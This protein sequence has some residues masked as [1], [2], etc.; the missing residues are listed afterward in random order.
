MTTTTRTVGKLPPGP[1][2]LPM[3]GSLLDVRKNPHEVLA[4]YAR[5]YGDVCMFRLGGSPTVSISHPAILR[6][7]LA[8]DEL[9]DR[10]TK[11]SWRSFL[12]DASIL[13]MGYSNQRWRVHQR[14][15]N[16]NVLSHRR[17]SAM[18]DAYIEPIID[19]ILDTVGEFADSG[20]YMHPRDTMFF[21]NARIMIDLIFGIFGLSQTESTNQNL[22]NILKAVRI[23]FGPH[24]CLAPMSLL[25][26]L[27]NPVDNFLIPRLTRRLLSDEAV[28]GFS[29]DIYKNHPLFDLDHPTCL[30]EVLLS[31]EA[32][33]EIEMHFAEALLID[34]LFAGTDTNSQTMS[35]LILNLARR[36]E[37]QERMYEE[38]KAFSEENG[39]E[40]AF[41]DMD[42]LPYSKA[43]MT[44]NFRYKVVPFV[45]LPHRANED[46]E[47]DGYTIPKDT[48]VL[49]NLH[50]IMHD[51]RFW[52]SPNE[53]MPE[54]FLPEA[55]GSP[56]RNY[57]NEAYMPFGVGRRSC[58][59][60]P[61]AMSM[62]WI[63]T[64]RLFRNF[65]FEAPPNGLGEDTEIGMSLMPRKFQVKVHR[66]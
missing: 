28:G 62:L 3:V 33:G 41:E 31:D 57:D 27:P 14:Y 32:N 17:V 59:G 22:R 49:P 46:C 9:S 30:L 8:M 64:V 38:L 5:Q 66:R 26:Y 36:P 44:E 34:L 25:R 47:V 48:Q 35:W 24:W 43:V 18:R 56:S 50:S 20:Q 13:V 1:R 6:E 21:M 11:P 61:L 37:I 51:E 55:D 4:K 58:P 40:P 15:I 12:S 45:A 53:F 65:R 2:G 29:M 39:R 23:A 54:R 16:R 42:A 10:W 52:D 60:Q 19:L 63:Q 7:A